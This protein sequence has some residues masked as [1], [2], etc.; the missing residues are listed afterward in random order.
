MFRSKKQCWELVTPMEAVREAERELVM[1]RR[2]LMA[3]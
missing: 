1:A 2:W 3:W